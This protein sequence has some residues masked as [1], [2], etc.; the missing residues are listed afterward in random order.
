[1][2][3]EYFDIVESR[4]V[5]GGLSVVAIPRRPLTPR[6]AEGLARRLASRGCYVI[7]RREGA[8]YN[9]Y[10]RSRVD[11][12]SMAGL[13]LLLGALVVASLYLS[14]LALASPARELGVETSSLAWSPWSYVLGLLAPL[15]IHE[16][17]HY[18]AMKLYGVPS[19]VPIPLPG[20]PLQLGFL[21]TFGS[22]ILMRWPPPTRD[23]L[24]VIGIAGPLAGFLAAIPVAILGIRGSPV[25]P[26]HELPQGSA[27]LSIIP[28]VM[29]LLSKVKSVPEGYFVLLSPLAFAS[30]VVFFVTFLNLIP[31]GQLDGGHVVRALLGDRGHRLASKL[32]IAALLAASLAA[33]PL[34]L[35]ALL[36]ILLYTLSGGAHPG[37]T[38]VDEKYGWRSAAAGLVYGLL[39]ALTLP[40]PQG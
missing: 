1:M 11:S 22:V 29:I 19:S 6:E 3:G 20:P 4:G 26:Y 14:G 33:P 32:F 16:M 35:F 21:G 8:A 10:V 12:S 7:A 2:L 15:L 39:L 5:N 34:F 37:P 27:P 25:L 18:V 31:I 30:Y 40:V 28:L 38:L 23:S 9:M 13:A 17:G 24:S 36:A